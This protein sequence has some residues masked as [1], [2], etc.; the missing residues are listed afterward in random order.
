M[1]V[2]TRIQIADLVG[3]AFGPGGADR[4]GL[5]DAATGKRGDPRVLEALRRLPDRRF[6]TMRDLWRHLPDM[7]VE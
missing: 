5:V 7:P 6:P 1:N 4:A 2:V 3:D